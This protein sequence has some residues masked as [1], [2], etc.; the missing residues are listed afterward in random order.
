MII[1]PGRCTAPPAL[2]LAQ[3]F[4]AAGLPAGALNVLTGSDVMFG[5]KVAQNPN[6]SYVTYSGNK[7]VCIWHS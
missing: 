3:L 2:M 6:I 5:A 7:Q 4:A 1:V